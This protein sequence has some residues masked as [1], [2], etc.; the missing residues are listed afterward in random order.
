M[1]NQDHHESPPVERT[2]FDSRSKQLG[3]SGWPS[4]RKPQRRVRNGFETSKPRD[5]Q[6]LI[7]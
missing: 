5:A 2:K 6:I 7:L 1:G 3:H 4:A